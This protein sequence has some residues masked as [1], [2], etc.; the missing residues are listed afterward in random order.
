MHRSL[1]I[2]LPA[3]AGLVLACD[4]TA[5]STAPAL[6][7][8]SHA[9]PGHSAAPS[10]RV[11]RDIARLRQLTAPFHK[12]ETAAKAGWGTQITGCFSDPTLGGMGYHYGNVALID[13]KVDLLEPELLLYE[14]QKN[15][16]LR[17]VAVEYIV[18]FGAWTGAEPP[19][20]FDQSFHRNEA[21][22]LWVL[23]V[24]HFR[25]N[26]SGMFADWNPAVSCEFATP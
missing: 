1:S 12:F 25:H 20:L 13:G 22:G 6:A 10:A 5:E 8:G 9:A 14:P 7:P 17:L 26:P 16:K 4:R 18:P 21:F 19:R 2:A 11:E 15:G 24:W 23:H 3:L